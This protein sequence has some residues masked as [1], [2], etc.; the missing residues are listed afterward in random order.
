MQ[1]W[2]AELARGAVVQRGTVD[3]DAKTGEIAVLTPSQIGRTLNVDATLEAIRQAALRPDRQATLPL[4]LIEPA[5][6][7]HKIDQ[8]GVK[9]LV[10]EG[11][12]NFKGSSAD[13]GPQHRRGG[14]R[15]RYTVVPPGGRSFSFNQAVGDV[16]KEYGYKDSL[17]IWG[18]RTAVGI[19]G[20]VCQAST[21]V[22]RAAYYGGFP[23]E[24]RWEPRL[25]GRLVRHAWPGRHDLYA[26]HRPQVPQHHRQLPDHQVGTGRGQGHADLQILR[27]QPPWQVE[28][29]GPEII[30]ETPPPPAVYQRDA[31]PARWAR[32]YARWNGPARA[33]TWPGAG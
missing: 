27:H 22:F 4:T 21:T 23:I 31:S 18:D 7:M 13:R 12:S 2:A 26:Q 17:I 29:T 11:T 24:E 14:G 6:N 1:S 16:S 15:H 9:E 32:V 3:F 28:V 25:C 20:G 33:W 30:K 10:A 5:V 8:M 19:G